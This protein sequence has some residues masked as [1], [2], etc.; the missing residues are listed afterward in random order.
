MKKKP[1]IDSLLAEMAVAPTP[2]TSPRPSP[3]EAEREEKFDWNSPPVMLEY[4]PLTSGE[5][6]RVEK[7]EFL[8]IEFGLAAT[9]RPEVAALPGKGWEEIMAVFHEIVCTHARWWLFVRRLFGVMPLVPG[10]NA[11][12]DEMRPWSRQEL[13]DAF[14]IS[15]DDLKEEI[16]A[17]RALWGNHV[18]EE[19]AAGVPPAEN[20]DCRQDAGSTLGTP[21]LVEENLLD[22]F[23]F[24]ES[25]FVVEW[26]EKSGDLEVKQ[27]R[28][29][30]ENRKEK[31]WF[32]R[33][34]EEWARMLREPMAHTI[35]RE[36]LL[37]ELQLKRIESDMFQHKSG[38][39]AHSS[40]QKT[41]AQLQSNYSQ[42][43]DQLQEMF[44]EMGVAGKVAFKAILSDLFMGYTR[45]I[46]S[47]DF[48]LLD[49]VRTAA[50]I[51][52]DVRQSVQVPLPKYRLGQT[53]YI[54]EA[55]HGLFDPNWRTRLKPG[56]LRK[57]DMGFAESVDR[58][59]A[60]TNEA[61]VDLMKEGPGGEYQDD[62]EAIA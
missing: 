35:A 23:G 6:W 62:A 43:M 18:R 9:S 7:F 28:P 53:L 37:D 54:I 2:G 41:R 56:F 52:V 19:C 58:V 48:K 15:L 45:A 39:P 44:P 24:S 10:P 16:E 46:A 40:L 59:R 25:M 60:E 49:R 27:K 32:C 47:G 51:S 42:R 57:L 20:V 5:R 38:A 22:E 34:L 33:R 61:L 11:H 36:C 8:A 55:M 14:G 21:L 31:A 30:E 3:L 4:R 1:T 50:E 13:C 26:S 29:D 12:P 17:V